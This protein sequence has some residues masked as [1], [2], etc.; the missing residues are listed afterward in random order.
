MPVSPM[1][2]LTEQYKLL[3]STRS[4]TCHSLLVQVT[5]A[6]MHTN[7]H[8]TAYNAGHT[9]M[10]LLAKSKKQ[11]PGRCLL[12]SF[13]SRGMSLRAAAACCMH[14]P[15]EAFALLQSCARTDYFS[16]GEPVWGG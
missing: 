13:L 3:A 6:Y 11:K 10:K 4:D 9:H 1:M 12:L 16:E 5:Q 15:A 2:K 14:F 7:A 8:A